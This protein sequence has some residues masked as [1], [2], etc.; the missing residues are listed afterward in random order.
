M[1]KQ[2]SGFQLPLGQGSKQPTH[3]SAAQGQLSARKDHRQHRCLSQ[4]ISEALNIIAGKILEQT[5]L[6]I[7]LGVFIGDQHI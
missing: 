4:I 7:L 5:F 3:A 1:L 6:L 2:A